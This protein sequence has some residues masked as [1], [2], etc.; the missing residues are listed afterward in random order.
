MLCVY[1]FP[2]TYCRESSV[3]HRLISLNREWEA[4]DEELVSVCMCVGVR[5]IVVFFLFL[6][7]L[8]LHI[9]LLFYADCFRYVCRYRWVCGACGTTMHQGITFK[10]RRRIERENVTTKNVIKRNL[11]SSFYKIVVVI[12]YSLFYALCATVIAGC[13][14]CYSFFFWYNERSFNWCIIIDGGGGVPKCSAMCVRNVGDV[15]R[16]F[17]IPSSSSSSSWFL[18]L[19]AYA[20]F[21]RSLCFP[22]FRYEQNRV[23]DQLPL[24]RFFTLIKR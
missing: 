21:F 8:V 6:P 18:S 16:F 22:F 5:V 12:F 23:C 2:A 3:C 9:L 20:C 4:Y 15:V 10:R 14:C 17:F 11:K 7:L 24:L 19:D 1:C 13:C